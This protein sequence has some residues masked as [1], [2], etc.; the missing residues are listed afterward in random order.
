MWS[1]SRMVSS[2]LNRLFSMKTP[3]ATFLFS[4]LLCLVLPKHSHGVENT[5][6]DNPT[7][8]TGE[9][10]GSVTTAGSYDPYTGNAKRFIDDLTVTGSVGAYPLKWTRILNTR[11]VGGFNSFGSGGSWRNSYQWALA[12]TPE[13][14]GHECD[15]WGSHA[16]VSHPDGATS[17]FYLEGDTYIHADQGE[18]G[19]RLVHVGGN[20]Y[21][22]RLKDGGRVE[23]RAV[24]A[25]GGPAKYIVDPYGQK[26]TLEYEPG[27]SRLSKISEP[28]GRYLEI[29]YATHP[30]ATVLDHVT[31]YDGPEG[32]AIETVTYNYTPVLFHTPINGDV[33]YYTL[34]TV[35][36]AG[37][38]GPQEATY[39][40][41]AP[42]Y[43]NPGAHTGLVPP[44][45]HTCRDVRF[46]GAMSNIEYEYEAPAGTAGQ[47]SAEKNLTTG[48]AVS[49]VSYPS[50]PSDWFTRVETRP[51]GAT[52][53]F[54]Y[55]PN[56][57]GELKS[58]TDF[59]YLGEPHH[60]TTIDLFYPGSPYNGPN[61]N[62]P[63]DPQNVDP[64]HYW[65]VVTDARGY[66]TKT[67]KEPN[68]GAV[69]CV[70]HH[71][72]SSVAYTYSHP[73]VPLDSDYPYFV[74]SKKDENGKFTYYD[75]DGKNRIWRIRYPD[76]GYETFTYDYDNPF[77]LVHEHRMTSGG[78][79]VFTYNDRG[80][81]ETYTPPGTPSDD[82]PHRT[83]YFYYPDG[84]HKD[85]LWYVVDPL[86]NATWYEYNRRGQV[87]KVTYQ[88]NT[89]TQSEYAA[90]GTLLWHEDELR[91]KTTYTYDEYKRLETVT[92]AEQ[93]TVRNDYTPFIGGT[94]LSHTTSSVYH[95]RSHMGKVTEYDYDANF[96]RSRMTVAP[97]TDEYA[98]T[99][100]TYDPV[101]N[102]ETVKDP[103]GQS[104]SRVTTYLY[105]D[106][107]LRKS[108]T[109]PVPPDP[110]P[111]TT[112]WLYDNVGNMKMETRADGKFRTWDLYDAMNRI[113]HTTGFLGATL[114]STSYDY[115]HAGNLT[116]M[117][118]ANQG[119][120]ETG[121]D[122]QLLALPRA[123]TGATTSLATSCGTRT[124]PLNSNI[125]NTTSV[126]GKLL[127]TG[128]IPSIRR[129]R[130]IGA[131][132]QRQKLRQMPPAASKRLKPTTAKPL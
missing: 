98:T 84:P 67:V 5:G 82:P 93:K 41:T 44:K 7:G 128:T 130:P 123:N 85:R 132:G 102:L 111:H 73:S 110:V 120:Y 57:D 108:M 97:T 79:E 43:Q 91:H 31:S 96:R 23:F 77:G 104:S 9:Y 76:G 118:D 105:N 8:V 59:A 18:P 62:P 24:T 112:T 42:A 70:I 40:Y 126:T 69:I 49:R 74:T 78:T 81:K 95:V 16:H 86:S 12:L 129:R 64:N 26:T 106:R 131:S 37:D 68:I 39:T 48:V 125:S 63:Q 21:D 17:Y 33:L 116:R 72:G 47:I 54:I 83:L 65:R 20:D 45:V 10:N 71:N 127:V 22:L 109:D 87:T 56:G 122:T 32:N 124:H 90:D 11:G 115:D 107:N 30:T 36:Y 99:T 13:P 117:T 61:N 50:G 19:D 29:S 46:N 52:R 66:E 38:N 100:Y 89:F 51:D 2:A 14:P 15:P 34:T 6:N 4:V 121:Y 119:V 101:G 27:S 75:R 3:L 60:T 113:K 80:L 25:T 114:E 94:N 88:N 53:K 55:S 92:N 35:T 58:Y 103:K 28:A 1:N